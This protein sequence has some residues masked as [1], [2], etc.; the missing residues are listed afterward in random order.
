MKKTIINLFLVLSISSNA[1]AN[2]P[3]ITNLPY[4]ENNKEIKLE[5]LVNDN[6]KNDIVNIEK[7]KFKFKY[8]TRL[9]YAYEYVITNNSENDIILKGINSAE[10]YNEDYTKD[11]NKPLKNITK[12]SLQSGKIYIPFYGIYYACRCDFE[13]NSFIRDFP[14]DKIIKPG[15]KFRILAS[16]TLHYENPQAEFVFVINDNEEAVTF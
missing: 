2:V 3:Y 7:N 11:S 4:R 12:A 5:K 15:G 16:S 14:K 13:K 6:F 1:Y 9:G 8:M 10:F